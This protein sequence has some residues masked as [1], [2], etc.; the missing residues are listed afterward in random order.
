MNIKL[1]TSLQTIKDADP[2]RTA[3]VQVAADGA[4]V[5]NF[6]VQG[7]IDASMPTAPVTTAVTIP[8][9]TSKLFVVQLL[10]SMSFTAS[11]GGSSATVWLRA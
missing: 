2:M 9:G 8:D 4:D 3:I 11:A 6:S 10:P 1:T 5:E 7:R